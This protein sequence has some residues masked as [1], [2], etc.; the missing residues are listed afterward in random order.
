MKKII[1]KYIYED[2][3]EKK[4]KEIEEKEPR[5]RRKGVFTGVCRSCGLMM[6]DFDKH[7]KKIY[8]CPRCEHEGTTRQPKEGV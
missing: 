6:T 8:T 7:R 5:S 1:T 4:V 2:I 3:T